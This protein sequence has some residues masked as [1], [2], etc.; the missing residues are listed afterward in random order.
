MC[1]F[2]SN[3]SPTTPCLVVLLFVARSGIFMQ[4]YDF[5]IEEKGYVN[6]KYTKIDKLTNCNRVHS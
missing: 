2:S 1:T 4:R 3:A 5:V 6:L